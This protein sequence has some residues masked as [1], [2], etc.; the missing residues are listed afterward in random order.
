MQY[1][2]VIVL[3]E[4][5][6]GDLPSSEG[7]KR[8][9]KGIELFK[10]G[11]AR[12]ITLTGKRHGTI[13]QDITHAE[14]MKRYALSKGI[15]RNVIVKEERSVDTTGQVIFIKRDVVRP[16]GWKRLAVVS[17][18]YHMPR[19][20]KLFEFVF[21]KGYTIDFFS[22]KTKKNTATMHRKER[23]SSRMND[24]T[25][26]GIARGDD[27]SMLKRLYER[28]PLYNLSVVRPSLRKKVVG[29]RSRTKKQSHHIR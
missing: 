7:K 21:G 24:E 20:R 11:V 12:S 26:K 3:S 1:D 4:R 27:E 13:P 15:D 5:T 10:Q 17:S 8:V 25:F 22:I 29:T 14:A 6:E 9:G 28:H 16:K 23:Q 18:D 19:V 2:T